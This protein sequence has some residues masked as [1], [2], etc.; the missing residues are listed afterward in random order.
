MDSILQLPLAALD[1]ILNVAVPIIFMI[2]YGIGQ[3][4]SNKKRAQRRQQRRP[5]APQPQAP[6]ADGGQVGGGQAGG[7][8]VD[9]EGALRQEVDDFLR[10]VQGKPPRQKPQAG[11][12][13]VSG[14]PPTREQRR[15]G[16]KQ[17]R[18]GRQQRPQSQPVNRPQPTRP[19]R[20]GAPLR[21][22]GEPE[23]G[24]VSEHVAEH[25]SRSSRTIGQHAETLGDV[26]AETD[27]RAEERLHKKFDHKIGRL[28]Q[29][30]ATSKKVQSGI[31]EEIAAMLSKPEGM[32]QLIIANE[33]LRR[34]F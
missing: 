16:R 2:L 25:I 1:D 27:E 29:Q 22:T 13:A 10:R 15:S 4:L 7:Q 23:R 12:P 6:L 14:A 3:L 30:K 20:L 33:I 31:A 9:L 26:L 34:P 11:R 24:G 21:G 32:R 17:A 18:P 5:R 8:P 19:S 28:Q